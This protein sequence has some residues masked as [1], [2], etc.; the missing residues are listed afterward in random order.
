MELDIV[1]ELFCTQH[2]PALIMGDLNTGTAAFAPILVGQGSSVSMDPVLNA[3]CG[4][5]PSFLMQQGLLLLSG[6]T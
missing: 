6:L 3:C 2:K 5:F 1:L 4:A